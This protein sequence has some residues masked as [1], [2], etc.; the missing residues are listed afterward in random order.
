MPMRYL[1]AALFV[2]AGCGGSTEPAELMSWPDLTSRPLPTPTE[3]LRYAE[4]DSG[5]VDVWLPDGEGPHPVVVMIHGGCWQKAIADRTLMNYAAEDLRQRGLAVWNIEYRGVDEEGGGY[6]GTF[7]DVAAAIEYLR[8]AP[9]EMNLSERQILG[10][11]HSAGGHLL[12]WAASRRNL[13]KDSPL[14]KGS[15]YPIDVAINSGGLADLQLSKAVTLPSCLRDIETALIGDRADAYRDTSPTEF[16]PPMSI[17]YSVNGE[18]DGIAPPSL[19]E[20]FTDRINGAGGSASFKLV[21]NTGH[22]ELISPGT[23]AWEVQAQLLTF[24]ANAVD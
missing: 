5:I 24:H 1:V 8:K 19:G 12:V 17:V 7:N 10:F 15:P 13:P 4:H 3:T 22:V 11:G 9:D 20:A 2:L 16:M 6:P 18:Q 21:P 14:Y 23:D